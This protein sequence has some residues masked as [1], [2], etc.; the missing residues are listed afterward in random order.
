MPE[1]QLSAL[2]LRQKRVNPHADQVARGHAE[3][4]SDLFQT[5]FCLLVDA[6][7]RAVFGRSIVL[8]HHGCDCYPSAPIAS[9]IILTFVS[10]RDTTGAVREKEPR[11]SVRVSPGLKAALER[12]EQTTGI[13]EAELVRACVRALVEYVTEHGELTVPLVM[14]PKSADRKLVRN[15][16]E[17][18][19][20]F[21][22]R[23]QKKKPAA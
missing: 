9:T 11:I 8:T 19:S 10:Q 14:K 13:A 12:V 6:R 20:T 1:I 7:R 2:D 18:I 3:A 4:L 21:E 15:P 5:L 17:E 23:P 22:E 16:S